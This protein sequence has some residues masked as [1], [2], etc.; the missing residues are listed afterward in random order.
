MPPRAREGE[1]QARVA[2]SR[3]PTDKLKCPVSQDEG[4]EAAERLKE[5]AQP[6]LTT[7]AYLQVACPSVKVQ[8]DVFYL[9]VLC[10]FVMDVFFCRLLMNPR[11]KENPA[12]HRCGVKGVRVMPSTGCAPTS[13]GGS[14]GMGPPQKLW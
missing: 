14:Q 6:I 2:A 5:Q 9:A 4:G 8:V 3:C 1:A 10:E 7:S 13:P 12:L 11:D